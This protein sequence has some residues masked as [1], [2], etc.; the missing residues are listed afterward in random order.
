MKI[1]LTTPP[2]SSTAYKTGGWR[3]GKK[4]KYLRENCIGCHLCQLSCPE[5]II[6]ELGEKAFAADY[7]FCK[8]CGI[9]ASVCPKSD[10][11]MVPEEEEIDA[12]D[13]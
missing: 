12:K 10:I 3:V 2:G 11:E 1:K 8:G 7:D 6:T 13:S 9:C 5:G 4:P